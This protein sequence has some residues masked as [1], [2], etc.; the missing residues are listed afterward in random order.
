[1]TNYR[2]ALLSCLLFV[3]KAQGQN[4]VPNPSF[5]NFSS[6]PTDGA[7]L[8]LAVPWFNPT[9]D[10][11]DYFNACYV[12]PSPLPVDVPSN[13][14]GYQLARTGNGYAGFVTFFT[15]PNG[16]EYIEVKLL[17]SLIIDR[18]YCVTFYVSLTD[19]CRWA[20]SRIGAYFST[21]SIYSND[22]YVLN[23]VPQVE[24][25]FGNII[26]DVN[27]WTKISG[28]FTAA[29]GEIFMTIGNFYSDANTDTATVG[30][31][32]LGGAYYYIDDVSVFELPTDSTSCF[33]GVGIEEVNKSNRISIYP[34]PA[35]NQITIGSRLS[36]KSLVTLY[37]LY[38]EIVFQS[39]FQELNHPT[40]NL[41]AYPKGIYFLCIKNRENIFSQKV[42]ISR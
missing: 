36:G 28:A 4:L 24:N 19:S 16:R 6:C 17:D 7:Q 2:I 20:T 5:E 41:S 3:F 14:F 29:G 40:I 38:G 31:Y 25:P 26:T 33:D 34:N 39:T 27:N 35:S 8:D 9:M 30:N 10:T 18:N 22:G 21:D 15:T 11:P 12:G 23:Y 42:I 32:F 13:Y 1:M 37:N